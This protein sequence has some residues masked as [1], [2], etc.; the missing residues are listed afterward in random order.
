MN[1]L[2]CSHPCQCHWAKYLPNNVLFLQI[3]VLNSLLILLLLLLLLADE[4]DIFQQQ[5]SFRL[6]RSKII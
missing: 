3:K 2:Q 5:L 1:N 4:T 6:L